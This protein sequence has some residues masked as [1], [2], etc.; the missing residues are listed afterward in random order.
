[1]G[2]KKIKETDQ[3]LDRMN[4]VVEGTIQIGQTTAETLKGQTE[5]MERIV[6]DLE[7]VHFN[8]KKAS[9]MIRDITRTMATDKCIMGIFVLIVAGVV[10]IVVL[11]AKGTLGGKKV[12]EFE[13]RVLT[14]VVQWRA[15]FASCVLTVCCFDWVDGFSSSQLIVRRGPPPPPAAPPPPRLFRRRLM[16]RK[17][18][19]EMLMDTVQQA[20]T[21]VLFE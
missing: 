1:M 8:L 5:Q 7:D 13:Q 9:Q 18:M 12:R 16:D 10:A 15:R 11:R 17:M 20:A 3:R 6:N 2:R 19:V 14:T 4:R 21:E